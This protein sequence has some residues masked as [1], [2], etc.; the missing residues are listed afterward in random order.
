M[1]MSFSNQGDLLATAGAY[2]RCVRIWD[3]GSAGSCRLIEGHALSSCGL[4][5]SPDGA[6]L[7]TTGGDGMVRLWAVATGRPRAAL[8][9]CAVSMTGVAFSP[10]GRLLAATTRND[11]DLRVWDIDE[12]GADPGRPARAGRSPGVT[13]PP[14]R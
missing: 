5:F 13:P 2:E 11:N 6:T 7:A 1:A 8:D 12:L 9:G 3:L 10:D 14:I 4:A